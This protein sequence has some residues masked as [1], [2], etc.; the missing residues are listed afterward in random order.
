MYQLFSGLDRTEIHVGYGLPRLSSSDLRSIISKGRAEGLDG[1]SDLRIAPALYFVDIEGERSIA[2]ANC[3][4]LTTESGDIRIR[5]SIIDSWTISNVQSSKSKKKSKKTRKQSVS[6]SDTSIVE[7][8]SSTREV[9]SGALETKLAEMVGSCVAEKHADLAPEI[10]K[11]ICEFSRDNVA[12]IRNIRYRLESD[13]ATSSRD[14]SATENYTNMVANLLQLNVICG[15]AADQAREAVREGL[16]VY[17]ADSMAYHA[18]RK[19]RDP[20]IVNSY[21]PAD[22]NLRSWMRAHDAAIRQCQQMQFQLEAESTSIHALL[23]SA[24]SISSSREADAQTRFNLLVGLVSVGLG[25]PALFLALYSATILL[26]L[27]SMAKAIPFLPVAFPLFIA[28]LFALFKPPQGSTR[29]Y[30]IGSGITTLLVLFVLVFVAIFAP[31][32]SS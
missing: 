11:R 28:A 1:Y 21:E 24:S 31:S 16:W 14:S 20:S 7:S 25:V 4:I 5:A 13:L 26:P 9:I 6:R 27:N 12:E 19:L 2:V 32:P 15:R 22:H 17:A 30:W 3:L 18:Y 8:S 23:S 29:K 10:A